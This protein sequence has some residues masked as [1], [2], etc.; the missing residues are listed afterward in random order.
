MIDSAKPKPS[1]ESF[2]LSQEDDKMKQKFPCD[3]CETKVY[4]DTLVTNIDVL[5]W[6]VTDLCLDCYNELMGLLNQWFDNG[7]LAP[8][9]GQFLPT[10]KEGD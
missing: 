1:L 2:M 5:E 8:K 6:G 4:L 3:R 7:R 9:K 10:E